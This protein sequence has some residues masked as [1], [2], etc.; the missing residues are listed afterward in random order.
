[1]LKTSFFLVQIVGHT[2]QKLTFSYQFNNFTSSKFLQ[3]KYY[4]YIYIN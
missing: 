4:A 3:Q 1:M 2:G